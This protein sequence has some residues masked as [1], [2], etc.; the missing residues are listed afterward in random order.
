MGLGAA[1]ACYDDIAWRVAAFT[2]VLW[3][4]HAGL[5][6]SD[7]TPKP[8]TVAH[9]ATD[10]YA[11]LCT[12]QILGPYIFVG[13]S[14]GELTVRYYQNQYS[15]D[16]AG[17]I[18]IDSAHEEQRERLL[19]AL[20]P[21]EPDEPP[22]VAQYRAALC[23]RWDDP[24]TNVE[25]IDNVANSALMRRC[26]AVGDLPLVVVS[27][28]RAQAPAGLPSELVMR[29]EHAWRIMQ[30]ELAALSTRSVH[31]TAEHSG[32]LVHEE[33]PDMAVEGVRQVLALTRDRDGRASVDASA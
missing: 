15:T 30:C 26:T 18:L 3:Y 21:P 14:L 5:G 29:R 2:R 16:V 19:A 4:D 28:G 1:G 33:Q 31:L 7:P 32:H 13:H 10:L 12:A 9:L 8:R 17:L 25:G 23:G 27:R 11:L 20:P 22:A 6:R 24:A